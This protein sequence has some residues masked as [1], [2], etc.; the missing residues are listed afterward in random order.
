[1]ST[2]LTLVSLI[3]LSRTSNSTCVN[4]RSSPVKFLMKLRKNSEWFSILFIAAT[5]VGRSRSSFTLSYKPLVIAFNSSSFASNSYHIHTMFS[6][7]ILQSNHT[8][9]QLY[10]RKSRKLA[11]YTSICSYVLIIMQQSYWKQLD[12]W[13]LAKCWFQDILSHTVQA[14]NLAWC[15]V[16]LFN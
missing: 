14:D 12:R 6:L 1:V 9:R 16:F 7:K 15:V 11:F 4:G 8:I 2:L 5:A 3:I 10:A 13:L